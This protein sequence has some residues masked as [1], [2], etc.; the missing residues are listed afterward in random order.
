MKIYTKD[1]NE[2]P[3]SLI[4]ENPRN[5]SINGRKFKGYFYKAIGGIN[6]SVFDTSS[7]CSYLLKRNMGIWSDLEFFEE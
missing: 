2:I 6:Y 3:E 1:I 4:N 5:M 7:V